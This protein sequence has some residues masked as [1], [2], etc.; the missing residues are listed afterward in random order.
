[1]SLLVWSS[2]CGS[3]RSSFEIG[4]ATTSMIHT[5]WDASWSQPVSILRFRLV[6]LSLTVMDR[7]SYGSELW[8]L[9]LYHHGCLIDVRQAGGSFLYY[10][11]QNCDV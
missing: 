7:V 11:S 3:S 2:F 6:I 9:I 5:Y 4:Y 1:M 10:S 8:I